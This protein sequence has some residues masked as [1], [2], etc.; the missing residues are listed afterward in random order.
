M[1][2]HDVKFTYMYMIV[3]VHDLYTSLTSS[4][5]VLQMLKKFWAMVRMTF[6]DGCHCIAPLS[7]RVWPA[8]LHAG[9]QSCRSIVWVLFSAEN[10]IMNLKREMKSEVSRITVSPNT[11]YCTILE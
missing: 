4:L 1:E 7:H 3:L 8:A 2:L 11:A 10:L 5:F 9:T 6:S